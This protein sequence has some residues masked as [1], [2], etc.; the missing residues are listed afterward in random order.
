MY[1][2][3]RRVISMNCITYLGKTHAGALGVD[4]KRE[5]IVNGRNQRARIERKDALQVILGAAWS[6]TRMKK[7]QSQIFSNAIR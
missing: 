6:T 2:I 7:N 3:Q 5:T 4:A 1:N